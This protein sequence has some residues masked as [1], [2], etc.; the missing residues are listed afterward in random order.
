[1]FLLVLPLIYIFVLTFIYGSAVII[2]FD[3]LLG[4]ADK[5]GV[6]LSILNITGMIVLAVIAGYLSLF[7]KI[8]MLANSIVSFL[9]MALYL[10]NR[11]EINRLAKGYLC[12]VRMANRFGLVIFLF[13]CAL[14]LIESANQPKVGDSGLYHIPTIKWIENY[15][16]VPGLG[17]LHGIYAFN[18]MWHPLS[19]L[20]G[21]SFFGIESLHILNGMMVIF[22]FGF[23]L[24]GVTDILNGSSSITSI[25]KAGTIPFSLYVYRPQIGSPAVDLPAAL[26]IWVAFILCLENVNSDQR[27]RSR[28][29]N[30]IIVIVALY[31]STIKLTVIPVAILCLY[32]FYIQYKAKRWPE[33]WLQIGL[34]LIIVVPWLARN[35]VLSGYLVYP[36]PRVDLF[37]VDWKLPYQY[38]MDEKLATQG[39]A[40]L[41]GPNWKESLDMP[42]SELIPKWF[43]WLPHQYKLTIAVTTI[44]TLGYLLWMLCN[45]KQRRQYSLKEPTNIV[46]LTAFA[47]TLYWFMMAPEPRYVFGFTFFM[48]ALPIVPLLQRLVVQFPLLSRVLMLVVVLIVLLQNGYLSIRD[49]AG[50]TDIVLKPAP[51]PSEEL[52]TKIIDNTVFYSPTKTDQCWYAPLPCTPIFQKK[53]SLRGSGL[54]SGFRIA[55]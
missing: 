20:F 39:W 38:V 47:G 27:F 49:M 44:I 53:L 22:A 12:D 11:T 45:V 28:T 46:Y 50:T 52:S 9:A 36:F 18:S 13:V 5:Q 10:V 43:A 35:I 21:F 54:E 55:R 3:K 30:V 14:A 17:N 42:L 32:L 40:R 51:Y 26:L 4:S 37:N 48:C 8:G 1:M 19:A 16:I 33:L 25:I 2:L 23:F 24:G 34:V 15:G 31:V 6:P 7:M 41:P 29:I